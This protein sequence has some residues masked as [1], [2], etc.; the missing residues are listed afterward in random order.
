MTEAFNIQETPISP[1]TTLV[2]AGAGTGKTYAL[3]RTVLRLV[4]GGLL[5][6][7]G[8]VGGKLRHRIASEM[9][10]QVYPLIRKKE[11]YFIYR[12]LRV[13]SIVPGAECPAV[14]T[15]A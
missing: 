11:G 15:R 7:R 10:H 4:L 12:A 5:P 8:L 14:E 2:E 13:A 6:P 3:T 9:Q 1:G